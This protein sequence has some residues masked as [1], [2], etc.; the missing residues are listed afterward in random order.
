MFATSLDDGAGFADHAA[1]LA[2]FL[3]A[4]AW[5]ADCT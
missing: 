4:S 5:S 3:N 2:N 1:A